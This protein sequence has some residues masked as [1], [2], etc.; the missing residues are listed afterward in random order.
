M[1]SLTRLTT[2]IAAI[3]TLTIFLAA[4]AVQSGPFDKL[5]KKAEKKAE[6]TTDKVTDAAVEG[7][8]PGKGEAA[9]QD[10]GAAATTKPGSASGSSEKISSV[11][12][13]FDFVPGDSV[14]FLDD[15]TQD[16]LGEFPARW[17]L[18]QGTFEIAELENERWLR[19][20]STDGR[21]RMKLPP[22]TSLPEFWTLEFD[23]WGVDPM[24]SA[25]TVR[26]LDNG[27]GAAWE[28]T[29]PYGND[30]AFRSGQILATTPYEGPGT[31]AGSHHIMFMARGTALKA[32]IDRQR[33]ANVPDISAP[34][35][36]PG[37]IEFRLW[38]ST[39]PMIR[40]VRFAEGC[41]PPKELLAEGKLVTYG[42][43]FATGSDV[44]QPESAPV[45]RQISAYLE[46]HPEVRL[47]ITG[48]TDNVGKAPANLDLSTRRAAAVASVL[49]SQFNIA[50]DRFKTDGMGDTKPVASNAKPEG[51]AM[52]RR[53]EFTKL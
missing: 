48:H 35:G 34:V 52:N 51:R 26:A 50:A 9:S 25:L 37:E 18:V 49:S 31:V 1:H 41:R 15:F 21:V 16:D 39:K 29:F 17:R 3:V 30:M 40:N 42:I 38:A 4:P 32:Y 6:E 23:F 7:A 28:A 46:A 5:K 13:K 10:S 33:M 43:L 11:S 2:L 24:G 8:A 22:M 36:M 19:C 47:Q 12:T 44:V 53:V 27:D 14:I 45:L 20:T